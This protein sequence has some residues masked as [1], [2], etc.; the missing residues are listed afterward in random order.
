MEAAL[1]FRAEEKESRGSG[2]MD[3][4]RDVQS[5]RRK[6]WGRESRKLGRFPHGSVS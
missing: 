3:A 1:L 2:S 5:I 4:G 6:I